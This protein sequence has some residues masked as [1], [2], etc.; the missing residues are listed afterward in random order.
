[1]NSARSRTLWFAKWETLQI[2][3]RQVFLAVKV[4]VKLLSP[5]APPLGILD[6]PLDSGMRNSSKSSSEELV[7]KVFGGS[8][9]VLAV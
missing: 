3:S 9:P 2:L 1:M 5:I 4:E 6:I 7:S 8:P